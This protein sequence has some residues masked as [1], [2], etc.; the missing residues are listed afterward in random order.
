[1]PKD[2]DAL[3]KLTVVALRELAKA[4]LGRGL[5][6]L[7]TKA[8]LIEA[9][10]GQETAQAKPSRARE[11]PAPARKATSKVSGSK[12]SPKAHPRTSKKA[13]AR[14]PALKASPLK[15]PKKASPRKVAAPALPPSKFTPSVPS[16]RRA[17][18]PVSA[19]AVAGPSV[20]PL[21]ALPL[22]GQTLLVRWGR[23]PAKTSAERLELEVSADGQPVRTVQLPSQARHAYVSALAVGQVYRATLV[24]RGATGRRRVIGTAS[25]PVVFFPP[26][27]PPSRSR[28][29]QYAW[30]DPAGAAAS[31]VERSAPGQALP[32]PAE[33]T[34]LGLAVAGAIRPTSPAGS[35]AGPPE[36]AA[37]GWLLGS[38][39]P[40]SFFH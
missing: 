37:L 18:D 19:E 8:Q 40:T 1:M 20:E 9:L 21:L 17:L 13:A 33:L 35:L 4:K 39:R 12:A 3:S 34:A 16:S 10:V 5:S 26:P 7:R 38:R 11:V 22:D 14:A 15:A 29:V 23:V 28:F 6:K 30:S 2:R 36:L 24:A 32:G 31:G 25:R 27:Q